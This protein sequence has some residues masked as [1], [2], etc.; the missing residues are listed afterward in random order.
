[1]AK[2][3][4]GIDGALF[5]DG[6]RVGK[7]TNWT[8]QGNADA[9]ETTTLG[10]YARCYVYGIQSY[11]G[12]CTLLYYEESAGSIVG[13]PLMSDVMRT[14]QTPT[15]GTHEI[16]L[17][18]LN[19]AANHSVRFDCLLPT[20]AIA[21]TVGGVVTAEISFQVTGPLKANTLAV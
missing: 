17:R 3:F 9:L 10:D 15:E 19:G 4:T 7:I 12:S 16:E 5:A 1:M 14:T 13:A 20:V 21:A 18:Y 11:S 8:F 2:Q 6:N